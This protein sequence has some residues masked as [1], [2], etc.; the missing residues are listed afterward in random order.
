[1]LNF[2]SIKTKILSSF[3]LVIIL[4]FS[5]GVINYISFDNINDDMREIVGKQL[6]LLVL[7]EDLTY[8]M[9]QSVGLVYDYIL[10]GDSTVK[11][12]LNENFN[13]FNRIEEEMLEISDLALLTE[14]FAKQS[15][16][17]TQIR[18]IIAVYDIGNEEQALR[19]L[20]ELKPLTNEIIDSFEELSLDKENNINNLGNEAMSA[21]KK[22]LTFVSVLLIIVLVV[23]I[24]VGI[25]TALSITRPITRVM[26]RMNEVAEG[27]LSKEPL[28]T[29]TKDEVAQLVDATNRMTENNRKLLAQIRL[30][31]E[32][33]SSQSEELTQSAEEVKTGSE[34]I[35]IT[36]EELAKGTETQANSAS[37]L[38]SIMGNFTKE[39]EEA[40]ENGEQ[41][42]QKSTKVLE[43]TNE[44]S[45]LMQSST[46][47]MNKIYDIVK[48]AVNKMERLDNQS[49][50]IS[51]LVTVIKEVAEQTNL[52]ALNAAI[53][54]ARAGEHGKGFAVVA[55]E[56]RK[57]AEQTA[58]SIKD[59]TQIVSDVK[60]ESSNV[61]NSLKDG[62]LEVEQGTKQIE[63]TGKTFNA[64]SVSVTEMVQNITTVSAKLSEIAAE[65]QEM[66]G[67]IEEVASVSEESSAG[68]EETVASAQQAH[69]AM[70]EISASSKHLADL[71]EELN[72]LVGKYKL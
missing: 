26:E 67:F 31:S 38:A 10:N 55:E 4:V 21:G 42:K 1:M 41:I 44:G 22:S 72:E 51:K 2:K 70:E 43:L 39:V 29:K 59:I 19:M 62:Y 20:N 30:V 32:S 11:E 7:D 14:L 56:V 16:W 17:E 25:V 50:E 57:L 24:G 18:E 28:I 69:S 12:N 60:T 53:E 64:I 37:E 65:T 23:S 54:A 9:S 68:V 13:E 36:M 58:S 66:N 71:A 15:Q 40:N 27:D 45:Q 5:M 34:Q 3:G 63:T 33:V 46:A 6:P 61:A 35:T 47:Q 52:L 48:D 49:Q 8:N